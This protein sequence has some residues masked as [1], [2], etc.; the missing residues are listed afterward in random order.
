MHYLI[1]KRRKDGRP[2]LW[3][4]TDQ[5]VI[6]LSTVADRIDGADLPDWGPAAEKDARE[7]TALAIFAMLGVDPAG[8][9]LLLETVGN[10]C[11][12]LPVSHWVASEVEL[13]Q[14]LANARERVASNLPKP[15]PGRRKGG[16]S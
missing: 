12:L 5:H 3:C 10:F 11:A 7:I 2:V 8:D 9:E 6:K 4:W 16:R 1:G 13:Q 15:K 14:L